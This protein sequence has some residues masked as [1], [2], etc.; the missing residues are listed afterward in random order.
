MLMPRGVFLFNGM[1]IYTSKLAS[2]GIAYLLP[3]HVESC[4]DCTN[5]YIIIKEFDDQR[6]AGIT[7]YHWLNT[8]RL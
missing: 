4:M 5:I 8:D 2:H 3:P 6:C 1:M 7:V